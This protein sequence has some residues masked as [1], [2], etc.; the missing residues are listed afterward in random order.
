M[1]DIVVVGAGLAGLSTAVRLAAARHRVVVCE[2]ADEVGGKVG[3]WT[4]DGFT[5][6]TG[7]SLLTLPAVYRDLFATTGPPLEDVVELVAVDP[8]CRYR[9]SDGVELTMP[10][11]ARSA[12]RAEIDSAL[13]TGAGEQ[14]LALL[15]RGG[16][17]WDATRDP[18]LTRP[19]TGTG[20]ALGLARRSGTAGLRTI[21][22]FTTLRRLGEAELAHPHL[23]TLLDRYATYAG[24]D[25]RRA[26]AAL[27][28][29][30]Y[31]E[32]TFGAWTVR[33]GIHELVL[34]VAARAEQLGAEIRTAAP[35]V[36]IV[37]RQGRAAGV[38]LGDGEVLDAH[39]VVCA[40][41]ATH[42]Y[43]DLLPSG[44]GHATERARRAVA[45]PGA[46]A[47]FSGYVLMLGIEGRAGAEQLGHHR[48]LF[49][50][51]YDDE[52]DSV[53]G[54]GE[55]R[56]RPR[57]VDD[58]TIYVSAPDDAGSRPDDD[59][60]AVFVLVNAPRHRPDKPRYGIDWD[61]AG[62]AQAYG[63]H[64]LSLL[65]GRGL[66]LRARVRARAHLTPADLERRTGSP[67]GALYGLAAHGL[68]GAFRR[69]A[70]ASPLRG[71]YLAGATTH[72]G[73]GLPLVGISAEIVAD[74]IGP[75]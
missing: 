2:Q 3:R 9:F 6:D 61:A 73:G 20:A 52:F 8:V 23:R 14:W 60:Q 25:P 69:P 22:P 37:T 26:P 75:A 66:D 59:S 53:F 32:Q 39:V 41:D 62:V 55:H 48:V 58:P 12:I 65:A 5:F 21:A 36:R 24:S 68:R 35:V 29:I 30:P 33:G 51:D 17:I 7:P 43:R 57:P 4:E 31:V 67:G 1:A 27:A 42:L 74:L 45:D 15:R 47:S 28:S 40:A 13:G 71:L 34:A 10:N 64:V 46:D 11:V 54:F 56:G 63:D 38:E 49:G 70:N 50:G 16:E 18:F 72:P 19:L 44:L